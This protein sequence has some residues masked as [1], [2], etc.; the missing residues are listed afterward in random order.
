MSERPTYTLRAPRSGD[1][2]WVIHRHGV[3]YSR[4]YGWNERFEGLVAGAVAAI[5]E[6][7]DPA[8]DRGWIA[9]RADTGAIV[10]SVFIVAASP[11]VAKLRL[12][13]VEP[14]ERGTGLGRRLVRECIAFS[15]SVGYERITLWTNSVLTA[16][17]AIYEKEGFALVRSE[18]HTMFGP[19]EVAETWELAL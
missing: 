17:R 18:P 8:R 9:V 12:L 13:Y 14:T 6:H 1:Y 3:L 5:I 16:A 10:G 15:R 11:T 7:H 4:E 2:G 19:G